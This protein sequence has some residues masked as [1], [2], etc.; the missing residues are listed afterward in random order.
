MK[1]GE[2]GG[3]AGSRQRQALHSAHIEGRAC[4]H[5]LGSVTRFAAAAWKLAAYHA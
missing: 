2:G 5:A 1:A 4:S 3:G